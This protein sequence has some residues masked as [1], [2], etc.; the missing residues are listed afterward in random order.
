MPFP[1]LIKAWQYPSSDEN[2]LWR[3]PTVFT[4]PTPSE[5]SNENE[6]NSDGETSSK[7]PSLMGRSAN[8]E[9]Y[10]LP[11]G[12][13]GDDYYSLSS[14]KAGTTLRLCGINLSCPLHIQFSQ[15]LR[16]TL[17]EWS[18]V[19]TIKLQKLRTGINPN[20][21]AISL[22]SLHIRLG[23]N[24]DCFVD[25]TVERGICRGALYSPFWISNQSGMKLEYEVSKK[26]YLD[27]GIGGLPIM[28]HCGNEG[29]SADKRRRKE[30][31]V[32]PLETPTVLRQW[33]D[34][35]RNGKLVM[36][37]HANGIGGDWSEKI[38]MNAA[39]TS[40]E[41]H[42]SNN[43]VFS[44]SIE[45]MAGIF[46]RSNLIR[47]TP[48]FVVRNDLHMH[49]S[50]IA[51]S[52][53]ISEAMHKTRQ[54]RYFL[55]EN[56]LKA[57]VDLAPSESTVIYSFNNVGGIG[58]S[59][60][61]ISF[62]VNASRHDGKSNPKWHL[63][64]LDKNGSTYL[65]EVDKRNVMVGIIDATV[66][67]SGG[68]S[69]LCNISHAAVPP[70]R[71][72][73]RSNTHHLRFAQDDDDA[74]VFELPPMHSCGYTWDNPHGKKRLR[75]EVQYK[76]N[77]AHDCRKENSGG[78]CYAFSYN[79]RLYKMN[80]GRK[81][82]LQYSHD[83][84]YFTIH[85]HVRI[86]SGT[87]IFTVNDSDFFSEVVASG[88]TSNG[89][90]FENAI[91]DIVADG[92]SISIVDNFPKEM[93]AI[94][95]RDFSVS[96]Q[97]RTN[98]TQVLV[99]HFQIDAM[100]P[101]ARY[102]II[103]QP[104]PLGIDHRELQSNE[105]TLPKDV[106][107]NDL[108]W[109]EH[110]EDKP[111]PVF[112]ANFEYIPQENMT[113]IPSLNVVLCPM[114]VAFDLDYILRLAS[115]F[116]VTITQYRDVA[117]SGHTAVNTNDKLRYSSRGTKSVSLTYLERMTIAPVWFEVEI[118]INDSIE[119]GIPS[120]TALS[121]NSIAQASN[122]SSIAGIVGWVVNVGSNFAHVTPCF[123]YPSVAY[124]DRFCDPIDVVKD[125]VFFYVVQTIKQ[126]L[127]I[128]FSSQ[129]LGD[130]TLFALQLRTG[131]TDLVWRTRDEVRA[132][133]SDGFGSGFASFSEN[134]IGGAF[135]AVGKVA[136][137]VAKTADALVET[138]LTSKHLK[139][140]ELDKRQRPRHAIDGF[141]L[142][143]QF[144]GRELVHGTAGL[145]G[146]P[147]RGAKKGKMS[148]L[149]KG[150]ATGVGNFTVCPFVATFGFGAILLE[151]F[152][153]TTK[154]LELSEI[155]ARC[156]PSRVVPWGMPLR[157]TGLS[158]L[159]AIGIRVHTVRYRKIRK[160]VLLPDQDEGEGVDYV[161]SKEHKRI[162]ASEM[163]RTNPP[164]KILR[165]SY[166]KGNRRYT[167]TSINPK[168]LTDHPGNETISHY[169]AIFEQTLILRTNN[170][171]LDDEVKIQ[172]RNNKNG[173]H[174]SSST[175][176][177]CRVRV[178]DIYS[179]ILNLHQNELL[180][181]E[182]R[183]SEDYLYS[184]DEFTYNG[185]NKSTL[186]VPAPQEFT[187]MRPP[188]KKLED[189]LE[190]LFEAITNE[191]RDIERCEEDLKKTLETASVHSDSSFP[192]NGANTKEIDTKSIVSKNERL[193]GSIS[194][195]FFPIQ[196]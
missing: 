72:E 181:Q 81:Q 66:N 139:P 49:I 150:F 44:V 41:V 103:C 171:Q 18:N 120:E 43:I 3:D 124:I 146:S 168:L 183:L 99:R 161:T 87:K 88:I 38:E 169:A 118:C 126:S 32:I 39:G 177:L 176:G 36:A 51:I 149:A 37:K 185:S 25:T 86:S 22:K 56:D 130:P 45:S 191:M 5:H 196:W 91:C 132:G 170:L 180:R 174:T 140:R 76:H 28:L 53:T 117:S 4:D 54:L 68:S 19:A 110:A 127:K 113:W 14:L 125:I 186:I 62:R 162:R 121:L 144:F 42:C 40:G 133:G 153:A 29:E 151:G 48:R 107:S 101:E 33:W 166:K 97:V 2:E 187:L 167:T 26:R 85:S 50:L 188:K 178:G 157:Q 65:G 21:G 106:N 114:K 35:Q 80:A 172:F 16:G 74:V 17:N 179:H 1:I 173:I 46:F 163:R 159:K 84:C 129:F 147:Y 7:S 193:F 156:R 79:S 89:G 83:D 115:N 96:K 10:H 52:G 67:R 71:I 90:S 165:I 135:F 8:T 131:L 122:S 105:L 9:L 190:D 116:V 77:N 175:L 136:K 195:S 119:D 100:D 108:F 73:N 109:L 61:W 141:V 12:S 20:K 194:L 192:G 57:N 104:L 112:E 145:I 94:T 148:S 55:T 47:F 30:I 63:V 189:P 102:P 23:D 15:K 184:A 152:G 58:N 98:A 154:Y 92:V 93:L 78:D 138:E 64:R 123:K 95:V 31:S 137:S 59:F 134:V 60:R 24:V 75:A 34:E 13:S 128:I 158:F 27:S 143:T 111:S 160:A 155:H 182:S 6:S 11:T 142:G 82:N 69:L 70:Y 164:S